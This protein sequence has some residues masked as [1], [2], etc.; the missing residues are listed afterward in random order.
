MDEEPK[1]VPAGQA[2]GSQPSEPTDQKTRTPGIIGLRPAVTGVFV[3][4]GCR[5]C[6]QAFECFQPTVAGVALGRHV[7]PNCHDLYEVKPEDFEAALDRFLPPRGVEEMIAL[8]EEATRV[9]ETW[10]ESPPLAR[11]LTYKGF[12]LG[13]PTERF[14]LSH[15]TLGL[16][17]AQGGPEEQ[18]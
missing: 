10:H 18:R 15:I 8:T 16:Y 14:L 11:L 2:E 1:S 9:A 7:C 4:L 6:K 5:S 17:P 12:N 13:E 3:L